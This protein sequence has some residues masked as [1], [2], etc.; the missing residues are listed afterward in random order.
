MTLRYGPGL[1]A[2]IVVC[3][4][5]SLIAAEPAKIAV[6]DLKS[7]QIK[8][9]DCMTLTN[10]MI[11]ELQKIPG[12]I[13]LAWDGVNKVF[14]YKSGKKTPACDDDK[15]LAE[16]G[17]AIGMD[18]IVAGDIGQIGDRFVMN[19]RLI[20]ISKTEIKNR[21]SRMVTG[22]MGL[23]ADEVPGLVAE[24]FGISPAAAPSPKK[25]SPAEPET[26][27]APESGRE[28]MVLI[29]TGTFVM[30]SNDGESDEK[31][32]HQVTVSGFYMDKTEVTQEQ[33]ERVMGN[34]PG[35]FKGC[36]TCPAEM[37]SWNDA[38]A[39]CEK[40]GKRLPTEAEWEYAARAGSTTKYSWGDSM[41]GDY[42][43]YYDNANSKTH[44]VGQKRPNAG[45]MYD[46]IGNVWEWCADWYDEKYFLSSPASNPQG[47][48][49]GSCRVLRGGSWYGSDVI[50]RSANRLKG[51][52]DN[53]LNRYGFRCAAQ[54]R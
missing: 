11:T 27:V 43:W 48:A 17:R 14:E 42:A 16:I 21:A 2:L 39:Y 10:F 3:I 5:A 19:I 24:L 12:N 26:K 9:E 33:Y 30:G 7:A 38:K 36:P 32:A 47:P 23:L 1:N 54:P 41:N 51:V 4:A 50:M 13:I 6:S 40:V 45:G 37:V 46:M 34:N 31:P 29:P 52:P 53:R 25:P 8:H 15:C 20:D 49:T 22:N 28:G 44:P 35:T 18:F